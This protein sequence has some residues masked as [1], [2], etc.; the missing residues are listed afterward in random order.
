[1]ADKTL[2][3]LRQAHTMLLDH[4]DGNGEMHKLAD[5]IDAT[6]A[7]ATLGKDGWCLDCGDISGDPHHGP[8]RIEG[9]AWQCPK[10]GRE[11]VCGG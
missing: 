6:L 1:M 5:R 3:L 4:A 11:E 9:R 2:S 10:C 8:L 7:A